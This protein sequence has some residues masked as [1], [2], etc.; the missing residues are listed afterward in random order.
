MGNGH[1]R[2]LSR[3][4]QLTR[5]SGDAKTQ[6]WSPACDGIDEHARESYRTPGPEVS[7]RRSQYPRHVAVSNRRRAREQMGEG[8]FKNGQHVRFRQGRKSVGRRQRLRDGDEMDGGRK[9]LVT[10]F[11]TNAGLLIA[12]PVA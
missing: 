7:R 6:P 5:L 12:S 2:R 1:A 11:S 4:H 8:L 9:V 10:P 3:G